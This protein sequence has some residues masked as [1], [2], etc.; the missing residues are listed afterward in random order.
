MHDNYTDGMKDWL[1]I[2]YKT[3]DVK[4]QN[5]IRVE[6]ILKVCIAFLRL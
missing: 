6:L 1:E 2:V 4:D 5:S 3:S